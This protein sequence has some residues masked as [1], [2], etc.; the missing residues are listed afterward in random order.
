MCDIPAYVI[1]WGHRDRIFNLLF[2]ADQIV[3]VVHLHLPSGIDLE[4]I[5]ACSAYG[6][7]STDASVVDPLSE[8]SLRGLVNRFLETAHRP[9]ARSLDVNP[10][11]VEETERR[12]PNDPDQVAY[13]V[14][15]EWRKIKQALTD[16]AGLVLVLQAALL[17]VQH[18]A[19]AETVTCGMF[20]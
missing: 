4:C 16:T 17:A 3:Y 11:F 6:V 1:H 19:V 13:E 10:G 7:T 9:L 14:L 5:A 8:A 15:A 2:H 18:T 20:F 12:H